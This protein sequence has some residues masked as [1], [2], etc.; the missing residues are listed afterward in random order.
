MEA[1]RFKVMVN[2]SSDH[3]GISAELNK[4]EREIYGVVARVDDARQ[5]R[6]YLQVLELRSKA[7]CEGNGIDM[8]GWM[9]RTRK[10]SE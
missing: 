2:M 8:R 3:A 9:Q 1:G 7:W 6:D 5:L 10:A 4:L